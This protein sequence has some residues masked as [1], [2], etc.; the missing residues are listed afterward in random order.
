M[1]LN[2]DLLKRDLKAMFASRPKDDDAAAEKLATIIINTI[3]T[4]TVTTTVT[5]TCETPAGPGIIAGTGT[6]SL[7]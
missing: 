7:S 6:G 2:K 4:A 3:K 1:A 5:G